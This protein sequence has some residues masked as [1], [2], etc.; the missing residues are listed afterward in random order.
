MYWED[1][2]YYEPTPADEIFYEA[3]QKLMENLKESVRHKLD[4]VKEEN[5][6]LKQQN[7]E[8]RKKI[9]NIEWRERQ[10]DEREKDL[11]RNMM[12]KKFSEMIKP[13]EEQMTIWRIDYDYVYGEKCN[14]CND[15]RKIEFT[16]PTGRKMEEYCTCSKTYT[17][18]FPEEAEIIRLALYKNR[19]YP[20]T[21]SVTP[22]YDSA[23]YDDTYCKFEL[24]T[25]IDSLDDYD[26][27]GNVLEELDYQKVGFKRLED[28]QKFADFL[29]QKNKLPKKIV[30]RVSENE[31]YK[32]TRRRKATR[33]QQ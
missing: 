28:C 7:E 30:K 21:V 16:S 10:L 32:P 3:Q 18:Y 20:Y 2:P 9:R 14:K 24:E 27:I 1:E 19:N 25:Y 8:L 5:E 6:N 33:K 13:L 4:L 17:Y 12:R 15:K 11:E 23:S 29:N 22:K 31:E 26:D